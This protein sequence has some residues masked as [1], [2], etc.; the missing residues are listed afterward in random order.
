MKNIFILVC[1]LCFAGCETLP[2]NPE[3]WMELEI[4]ACLP[5]AIVF[6]Q[7][8]NRQGIW[9]EVFRYSWRTD[10]G[11]LRGHAMV[12]YLYPPGKNKLWTYDALGSYRTYAYKDDVVGIARAAHRVRGNTEEVF[13]EEFIK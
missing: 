2:R 12:V 7:A 11:K 8:L 3:I 5:T 10:K 9:A 6:K 4:N 13:N 1:F